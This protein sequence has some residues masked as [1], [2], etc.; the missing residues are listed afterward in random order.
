MKVTIWDLERH[1]A[2]TLTEEQH[3]KLLPA[4]LDEYST[5]PLDSILYTR[6]PDS[7]SGVMW[8]YLKKEFWELE[9]DDP[10][11]APREIR[12]AH[13]KAEIEK[14]CDRH[15]VTAFEA[16]QALRLT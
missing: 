16:I 5:P 6:T 8:G 11:K 13:V 10:H 2:A 12:I 4:R 7:K 15:D 14:L 3:A 9:H 1:R